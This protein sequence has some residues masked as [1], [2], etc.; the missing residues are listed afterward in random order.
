MR[1]E[2]DVARVLHHE[3]EEV[4]EHGILERVELGVAGPDGARALDIVLGIGVEHVL[5]LHGGQFVHRLE[6]D[7]AARHARFAG[8]LGGALGDVLGE[9]ADAFEIAGYADR[10]DAFAQI[11]GHGLAA[12]YGEDRIV[13]DLALQGVE[14]R[15]D[16]DRL[17]R[18]IDVELGERVHRVGQHAF[19][20]AAHFG[21]A[22]AERLQLAVIGPNGVIGHR[23]LPVRRD[24]NRSGRLCSLASS[25][26]KAS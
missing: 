7:D 20:D 3:G 5:E 14:P 21:D 9:V 1:A 19:G 17:L 12:R 15:I 8:D 10:G 23:S 11:H 4:A 16:R 2:G 24:V 26:R 18:Q 6:P 22:L 13:L 25:C